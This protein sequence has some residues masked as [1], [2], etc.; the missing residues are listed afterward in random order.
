MP[1]LKAE[2]IEAAKADAQSI[3]LA[4]QHGLKNHEGKG[5]EIVGEARPARWRLKQVAN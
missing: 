1:S 2:G 4:V 5:V 3:A